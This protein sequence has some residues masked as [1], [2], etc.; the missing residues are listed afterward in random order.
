MKKLLSNK[1]KYK[2]TKQP[3]F[4][5]IELL[6]VV[7]IISLLSSITLVA[8]VNTRRSARDVLRKEDINTLTNA[9]NLYFQEKGIYPT[10]TDPSYSFQGIDT[11]GNGNFIPELQTEG[12]IPKQILGPSGPGLYGLGEYWYIHQIA[13]GWINDVIK[14]NYIAPVCGWKDPGSTITSQA[15]LWF[16][17]ESGLSNNYIKNDLFGINAVCFD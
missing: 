11:T 17:P 2:A 3:G 9:I 8:L 7:S 16:L 13:P 6:V 14:S 5:F 4:T 1:L 12:Y 15:T 10:S